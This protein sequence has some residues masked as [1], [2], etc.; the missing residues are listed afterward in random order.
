MDNIIKA[1]EL[2]YFFV[3]VLT[4]IVLIYYIKQDYKERENEQ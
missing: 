4:T 1:I 3:T 2:I